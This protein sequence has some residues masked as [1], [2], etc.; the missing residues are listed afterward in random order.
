MTNSGSGDERLG[1]EEPQGPREP[2]QT[3][4]AA[5]P[6]I[7]GSGEERRGR[8]EPQGPRDRGSTR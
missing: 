8:D 4:S 7:K 5:G 1:R 2:P 6:G 3:E